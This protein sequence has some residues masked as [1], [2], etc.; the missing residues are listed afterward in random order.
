MTDAKG[1]C[2]GCVADFRMLIAQV[3]S[4]WVIYIWNYILLT[5]TP[6]IQPT[7]SNIGSKDIQ[8]SPMPR[9]LEYLLQK[10]FAKYM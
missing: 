5:P 10:H 8:Y 4:K 6:T 9:I 1:N 7:K 3:K 2:K